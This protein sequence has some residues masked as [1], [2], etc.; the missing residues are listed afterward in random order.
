VESPVRLAVLD[1][2]G[3]EVAVLREETLPAGFHDLAWN[4]EGNGVPLP[5]GVYFLRVTAAG[6]ALVQKVVLLR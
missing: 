6:K 3:R 4:G 1:V 2:R 5:A